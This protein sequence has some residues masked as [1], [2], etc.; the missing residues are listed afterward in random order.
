LDYNGNGVGDLTLPVPVIIEIL[1]YGGAGHLA[2][3]QGMPTFPN[4]VSFS[5][6]GSSLLDGRVFHIHHD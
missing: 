2:T 3:G 4:Q 5:F 1:D 6:S